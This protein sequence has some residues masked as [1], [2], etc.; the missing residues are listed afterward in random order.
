MSAEA[1]ASTHT[2]QMLRRIVVRPPDVGLHTIERIHVV[3]VAV[4]HNLITVDLAERGSRDGN[5]LSVCEERHLCG[6]WGWSG[7]WSLE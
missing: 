7:R 5:V 3:H 1:R 6:S 4:V 2:L